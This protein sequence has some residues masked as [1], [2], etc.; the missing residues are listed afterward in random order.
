MS[1]FSQRDESK[2]RKEIEYCITKQGSTILASN[3][4]NNKQLINSK[5]TNRWMEKIGEECVELM[6]QYNQISL[7]NT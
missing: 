3:D 1:L 6:Q 5:M 2:T 4:S 7:F